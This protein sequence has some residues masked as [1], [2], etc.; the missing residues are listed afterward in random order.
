MTPE[1]PRPAERSWWLEEALAHPEFAGPE[2]PPLRGD[3]TADVVILGG[4]YTGMWTAWFL[5]EREPD[6]DVVLLEADICGGGPSG[7]NGGFVNG[8]YE[9][10]GILVERFGDEGRRTSELAARSIDE[11]GDWCEANGVDAAYSRVD[12]LVVSTSPEQDQIA[13]MVLEEAD[14]L[15]IGDVHHALTDAEIRSRFDSPVVRS[16]YVV[17]HAALVQPARLARGL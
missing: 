1:L 2:A 10:L 7:R 5:K 8:L 13:A 4:G 17:A 16:G 11:V 12:H 15:G 14:A 3:T 9:E 6:L